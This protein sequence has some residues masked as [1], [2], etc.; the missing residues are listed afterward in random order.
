MEKV[1]ATR[2]KLTMLKRSEPTLRATL[3]AFN[4]K[5]TGKNGELLHVRTVLLDRSLSA[6]YY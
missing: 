5:R 4:E 2:G 3:K 1:E 6:Y